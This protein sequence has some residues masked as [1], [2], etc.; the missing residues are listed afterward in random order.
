MFQHL[1]VTQVCVFHF[2]LKWPSLTSFVFTLEY[3][4]EQNAYVLGYDVFQMERERVARSRITFVVSFSPRQYLCLVMLVSG[5]VIFAANTMNAHHDASELSRRLDEVICIL[6]ALSSLFYVLQQCT[7][8]TF[9]S[10][11]NEYDDDSAVVGVSRSTTSLH[12][13]IRTWSSDDANVFMDGNSL[14]PLEEK[15]L[16]K[17]LEDHLKEYVEIGLEEAS[18]EGLHLIEG[19]GGGG[20]GG[21]GGG[22]NGFLGRKGRRL[23][24]PIT[25]VKAG[26]RRVI[27]GGYHGGKYLVGGGLHGGKLV[28]GGGYQGGKIIVVGGYQGGKRVL[29][30]GYHGAKQVARFI[31]GRNA[32]SVPKV[33]RSRKGRHA[34]NDVGANPNPNP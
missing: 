28:V 20:G 9:T 25:L 7:S 2:P 16:D 4:V 21:G 10:R 23:G 22:V 1:P 24:T 5:I 8:S 17:S 6:V 14:P 30:G 32:V 13:S 19:H 33:S 11:R 15:S 27:G 34:R 12:E 26:T 29:G 31:G 18:A 3:G